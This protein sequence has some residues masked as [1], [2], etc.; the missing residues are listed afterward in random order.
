MKKLTLFLKCF[1]LI[2][3]FSVLSCDNDETSRIVS[4]IIGAEGGTITSSD[5]RLTLT[6]PPGALDEDTEITIR[7]INPNDLPPEFDDTDTEGQYDLQPEG[8]EFNIPIAVEFRT[9]QEALDQDG[10]LVA[11]SILLFTPVDG[12]LELLGDLQTLINAD[13]N[14]VIKSGTLGHF[15]VVALT[16]DST[17]L[18]IIRNLPDVVEFNKIFTVGV[19]VRIRSQPSVFGFDTRVNISASY[20]DRSIPRIFP[21]NGV[22]FEAFISSPVPRFE[23]NLLIDYIC[24][25]DV[26]DAGTTYIGDVLYE[27]VDLRS[28]DSTSQF[29]RFINDTITYSKTIKC[30]E[31]LPTPTPPPP[32]LEPTPTP[33]PP[34]QA[35]CADISQIE[36]DAIIES[37]AGQTSQQPFITPNA[38]N[39]SR[40]TITNDNNPGV[41]VTD[42]VPDGSG[43]GFPTLTGPT[44]SENPMGDPQGILCDLNAF[45]RD[46][47]AGGKDVGIQ[48]L[49]QFVVTPPGAILFRFFQVSYGI[50]TPVQDWFGDPFIV[51]CEPGP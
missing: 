30:V 1:I 18:F 25:S 41:V 39:M 31:T 51:N 28:L 20:R 38:C 12:E 2:F 23:D 42:D 50:D 46:D 17:S 9:D 19:G 3:F 14:S 49:G 15:S 27:F 24:E 11:E 26:A 43:G 48:A 34:S 29:D 5:G 6:I 13:D 10:N 40:V 47:I 7:R 16:F 22:V 37:L 4:A 32:P 36:F 21:V 45:G 8:L 35:T 33:T 44:I